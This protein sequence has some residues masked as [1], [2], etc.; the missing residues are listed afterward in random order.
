M[1]EG[2]IG[3]RDIPSR[4]PGG[5]RRQP[6]N[7]H[8]Q[9]QY[10]DMRERNRYLRQKLQ[11]LSE[12]NQSLQSERDG[13]IEKSQ[14]LWK[15]MEQMQ[16]QMQ[17]AAT[18]GQMSVEQ[19]SLAKKVEALSAQNHSL[20]ARYK[21]DVQSLKN[22]LEDA[23]QDRDN[24]RYKLSESKREN[25]KLS[26]KLSCLGPN[27]DSSKRQIE[28][29][30]DQRDKLKRQVE[31]LTRELRLTKEKLASAASSME[32]QRENSPSVAELSELRA[33]LSRLRQD[34]QGVVK[35]RDRLS[36]E[37]VE[38]KSKVEQLGGRVHSLEMECQRLRDSSPVRGR[39]GR[40]AWRGS[41]E[42]LLAIR[43][44]E[45]RSSQLCK[46]FS[47]GSADEDSDRSLQDLTSL[48]HS[49]D[50]SFAK[51]KLS[52]ST[53]NLTMTSD[54]G[55]ER[56]PSRLSDA[57]SQLKTRLVRSDQ[58]LDDLQRDNVTLGA[59]VAQMDKERADMDLQ[60]KRLK[61]ELHTAQ[62]E[63]NKT[64]NQYK[65]AQNQ[66]QTL[67]RERGVAMRDNAMSYQQSIQLESKLKE[68]EAERQ[69]LKQQRDIANKEREKVVM[70]SVSHKKKLE[71][72]K[73]QRQK[74]A[75]ELVSM[76]H[77]KDRAVAEMAELRRQNKDLQET[78]A[79]M[80]E[81]MAR[82]RESMSH[83]SMK[84][85][86]PTPGISGRG[87][88]AQQTSS[89][90]TPSGRTPSLSQDLKSLMER[91]QVA[92]SERNL[93][94]KKLF[95]T[96]GSD[97]GHP[98]S[99]ADVLHK[100]ESLFQER[101]SLVLEIEAL[102][103]SSNKLNEERIFDLKQ[104]IE[105]LMMERDT[106]N[107]QS[108]Q[109]KKE[110]SSL[111]AQLINTEQERDK[112]SIE[113]NRL[114]MLCQQLKSTQERLV[115]EHSKTLERVNELWKQKWPG[116]Y[117]ELAWE[118]KHI[119][120]TLGSDGLAGFSVVGGRDQPQ[121]PNPGAFIVTTVTSGGPA[122]GVIKVGDIL[123]SVNGQSMTNADHREAVRA[124]KESR[125]AI[126]VSLRRRHHANPLVVGI[127]GAVNSVPHMDPTAAAKPEQHNFSLCVSK[128][129]LGFRY[130]WESMFRVTEVMTGGPAHQI[131]EVGDRILQINSHS[132]SHEKPSAVK[133]LLKPHKNILQLVVERNGRNHMDTNNDTGQVVFMQEEWSDDTH[134]GS[135]CSSVALSSSSTPT[136]KR[137]SHVVPE[138]LT[139]VS[140]SPDME[141]KA[142]GYSSSEK[143]ERERCHGTQ[144]VKER[145]SYSSSRDSYS[146][147]LA[148]NESEDSE[149]KPTKLVSVVTQVKNQPVAA[150]TRQRPVSDGVMYGNYNERRIEYE[151]VLL[152]ERTESQY[153]QS[154]SYLSES[155]Y[156]D[157]GLSSSE[158]IDL[159]FHS[160]S[161]VTHNRLT[162]DTMAPTQMEPSRRGYS[163]EEGDEEYFDR[164]DS[165]RNAFR[166]RSNGDGNSNTN[167][168]QSQEDSPSQL[169]DTQLSYPE[170]SACS[171]E[172]GASRSHRRAQRS[173]KR[174]LFKSKH[175]GN[176]VHGS[177]SLTKL[178][179]PEEAHSL[180]PRSGVSS[181]SMG[182]RGRS[183]SNLS[184]SHAPSMSSVIEEP[185]RSTSTTN[186]S[187]TQEQ[188]PLADAT[189]IRAN[190][191]YIPRTPKE[192]QIKA[193][194][195]FHIHDEAPSE[196]FRSCFWVSRLN[197]D[198][199]DERMGPIPNST[200]AQE[201]LE[202]QGES[203]DI[204]IY[205]EVEA[206]TGMRP[207]L[208]FGALAD[209]VVASLIES[210]PNLFYCCNTELV[211]GAARITEARLKREVGEGKI[212]DFWRT[213]RGYE[214]IRLEAL[215]ERENKSKHCLMT[216]TTQAFQSLKSKAPPVT[217]LI[218]A[219]QYDS[220]M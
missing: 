190:F 113:I 36:E 122:D 49:G 214:V 83:T 153:S 217:I 179:S 124:V 8:I 169:S 66:I 76:K 67:S 130:N 70:D 15:K 146:Q 145:E 31:S 3:R 157:Y 111:S 202:A 107:A 207:V 23:E 144:P 188:D 48:N 185:R 135:K 139:Q 204:P 45:Y 134:G 151:D 63:L 152:S 182:Q 51:K 55:Y 9:N 29:V 160:V 173:Y 142:T 101:D 52:S 20:Q 57:N 147:E 191:T 149:S 156:G 14:Q 78:I 161:T 41:S 133:K 42:D 22:A 148:G 5:V 92:D 123:E 47:P 117:D 183:W 82:I 53:S 137:R 208:I 131:L 189:Y 186:V 168:S 138:T 197:S 81:E 33:E 34:N 140:Q 75:K 211:E 93:L 58:A 216:G 43:K 192:L 44:R 86:A 209:Q 206:Y 127:V 212:V 46:R 88:V 98:A 68:L 30:I 73:S 118:E 200:K 125:G 115:A 219:M 100:V 213:D 90:T 108:K 121:L 126:A 166:T 158:S 215:N 170:M 71:Q 164:L 16:K 109:Q 10:D 54:G 17:K 4:Q 178:S 102:Q 105:D 159:T 96:D 32:P 195:V 28:S 79:G 38:L 61:H 210:Y 177:S 7:G 181:S 141:S 120:L 37:N 218:K 6:A 85:G 77:M 162:V 11:S 39:M 35:E 114:G 199:T 104:R 87:R 193:G 40:A 129:N 175:K 205:E 26:E 1:M 59:K 19:E 154:E 99:M 167:N 69:I 163:V 74:D 136:Y 94:H 132:V 60:L 91:L 13:A 97:S 165:K 187:D 143:E 180:P 65:D 84:L 203:L 172:N 110:L 184:L 25:D 128:D 21:E 12:K 196:R 62:L 2:G 112:L 201:Y 174:K 103:S 56:V 176:S 89:S 95:G 64:A 198:G 150:A 155:S 116:A 27:Y 171:Q 50:L 80:E 194:D 119:T 220:I 106:L 18:S 72:I 24:L